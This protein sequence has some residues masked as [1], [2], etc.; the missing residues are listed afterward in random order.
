MR[1][2]GLTGP[3]GSGKS[4][5]GAYFRKEGVPVIDADLLYR[6]LLVPP[7]PCLDELTQRF[8]PRI[9][10]DRRELN[11]KELASIVF[12]DT[13]ALADLN[14]ISHAH[15]MDAIRR[16][17]EQYRERGVPVAVLDAPQLF[18]AHADRLCDLVVSVLAPLPLRLA[19][20]VRR[21]GISEEDALRRIQ[22]QF[23]DAF[24][25]EHS[26]VVICNDGAS[27]TLETQVQSIL[28]RP[29]VTEP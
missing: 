11:R 16:Q 2:I 3:S 19:R 18:E 21:D 4:T 20:I 29:E 26:D 7:S 27:R 22:S 5:V 10:T 12:S 17:L 15:I 1:V 24:F 25:T 14:R 8:G 23:D 6:Q 28:R 9:L 13:A